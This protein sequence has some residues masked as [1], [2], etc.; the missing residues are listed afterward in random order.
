MLA[1]DIETTGIKKETDLITVISLYDPDAGISKVL[2]FVDLNEECDVCYIDAKEKRVAEFIAFMDEAETLNAFNGQS[3]DIP[4]VQIQFN[5]SNEK[6]QKWVLKS[7]DVLDTCRK[8]F[9]RTF[10]LNLALEMNIDGFQKSGSGMDAVYQARRGEWKEL[11][12]Y[13]MYDSILT[14]KLSS[15]DTILCPEGYQWRKNHDGRS[16]DPD[17]V[18]KIHRSGSKL[19]FSFGP[20]N[21]GPVNTGPSVT[22]VLQVKV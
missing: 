14:H 10:S 7:F 2:R 5:I 21:T 8:A 4:F 15:L 1:W 9:S 6:I 18:L 3:F 12:D 22:P 13:C 16:Y 20:V 19:T 11:E 17:H